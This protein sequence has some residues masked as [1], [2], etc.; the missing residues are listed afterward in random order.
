MDGEIKGAWIDEAQFLRLKPRPWY[1]KM[2]HRITGKERVTY[3]N[4]LKMTCTYEKGRL[5]IWSME[6]TK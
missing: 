6:M 2:W 1:K 5:K 3:D 4:G